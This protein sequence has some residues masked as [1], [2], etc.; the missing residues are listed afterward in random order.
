M[1]FYNEELKVFNLK[2][3]QYL[4]IGGMAFNLLGGFRSTADLDILID[5]TPKNVSSLVRVL[6]GLGYKILQPIDP[7][8][9]CDTKKQKKLL[10]SKNMKALTFI[11]PNSLH[12]IDVLVDSP[13]DFTKAKEH[14][15]LI[16][17]D[18]LRIPVIGIN[19][20]IL[21]K[22]KSWRPIDKADIVDLKLIKKIRAS[23]EK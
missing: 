13:V 2:K 20:L 15:I 23:N 7:L 6:S 10:K 3:I 11:K 22:K 19:E 9:I 18:G 8:D 5:L 14:A 12:Q 16:K 17:V 4:I 1:F 21:M